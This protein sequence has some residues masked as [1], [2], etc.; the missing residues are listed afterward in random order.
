M[1]AYLFSGTVT[2]EKPARRGW[3][4]DIYSGNFR[5]HQLYSSRSATEPRDYIFATMPQFPW[6]RYPRNAGQMTFNAIFEDFYYQATRASHRFACRITRS[7]TEPEPSLTVEQAWFP[8]A[9][10]PE[11]CNLGDFMKLL[12]QR[13]DCA[14][15]WKNYHVTT[16]ISMTDLNIADLSS[17]AVLVESA[18]RFSFEN[19]Q[20]CFLGDELTNYE[21]WSYRRSRS[22]RK[23]RSD[24]EMLE[25]KRDPRLTGILRDCEKRLR[26]KRHKSRIMIRYKKH[27]GYCLMVSLRFLIIFKSPK[28]R[29]MPI[30]LNS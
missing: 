23:K 9:Q 4:E 25:K 19:W 21:S 3:D 26:K 30:S 17:T 13:I 15:D 1:N 16:S 14:E 27:K 6:Y 20:R 8:S 18:M 29:M 28:R 2:R 7:M 12:G 11:P 22:L 10:Q 5:E 24:L